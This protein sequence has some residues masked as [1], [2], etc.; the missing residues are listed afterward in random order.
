MNA[1]NHALQRTAPAV[2]LAA[3][4]HRLAPAVQPARQPPQSLSLGSLGPFNT[5]PQLKPIKE[6]HMKRLIQLITASA[7][8]LAVHDLHAAAFVVPG[9]ST[10]WL[11]GMPNGS[12]SSGGDSAPAQSPILVLGISLTS[13]SALVFTASGA[14]TNGS[15]GITDGPDGGALNIHGVGAENGIADFT[16]PVNALLGIFLDATQPSL[17]SAPAAFAYLPDATTIFP[18]LRQPFFIGDGLTST[19]TLQQFIVPTGATRL[20]LGTMDGFEWNN[21]SGSFSGTVVPEPT[22]IVLSVFGVS[23]MLLLRRRRATTQVQRA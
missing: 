8:T 10:P 3:S 12:T 21:N 23:S 16:A 19:A 2:T 6:N 7:I 20:F 9:T 11:A 17:L 4:G 18:G 15:G 1:P 14:V 22:T 5:T 13:G